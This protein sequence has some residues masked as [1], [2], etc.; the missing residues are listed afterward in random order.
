MRRVENGTR[1][2]DR[3]GNE[4]CGK[5]VSKWPLLKQESVEIGKRRGW[6]VGEE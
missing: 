3:E 5:A 2:S 4:R 1:E 6:R